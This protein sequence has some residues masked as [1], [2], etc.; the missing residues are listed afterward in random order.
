MLKKIRSGAQTGADQGGLIAGYALDL[1]IEC[2]LPKGFKTDEGP[3][4]QDVREMWNAKEHPM[5]TYPPR[6]EYNVVNSDGTV[7]FG[8][9]TSPGCSLTMRLCLRHRKPYITNPTAKDLA[10]WIVAHNIEDL[11]VA[12]NRERTNP[13]IEERTMNTIM[14]AV[15]KH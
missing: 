13:G 2:M 11:N 7:L 3:L 6:T 12:G 9:M 4:P 5:S 14:D 1:D 15:R 10:A 8:N